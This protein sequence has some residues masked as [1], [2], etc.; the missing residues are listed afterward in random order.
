MPHKPRISDAEWQVMQVLWRKSPV[1]VREVIEI[2][3]KKTTWKSETIRTLVNRLTKKKAIG[4]EKKGRR[5]YF[6][7]LLSEEECV[8]ADTDSFLA[9][10]GTTML[11]PI[12]AAFIEKEQLS[13]KEIEELRQILAKKGRAR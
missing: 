9:R 2:L 6:Y 13:D 5:H 7:P 10:T 11:K 3:S 4:F 1:T 12:L 8:K